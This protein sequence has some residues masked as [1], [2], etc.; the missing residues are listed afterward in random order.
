V[1]RRSAISQ[2]PE[3]VRADLERELIDRG[4]AGY[5]ALSE[6]LAERGHEISK[7]ALHRHGS[8]LERRL[9]R[10][11]ASAEAAHLIVEA[12]GDD[13]GRQS[14]AA[15]ALV[16]TDLHE[17][18]MALDEAGEDDV[19]P[20]SRILLL[21]KAA[22]AI[23]DCTRATVTQKRFAREVREQALKDAADA[24]SA[25]AKRGGLSKDVAAELRR[26]ILGVAG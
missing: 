5:E 25:V 9:S 21:N 2:L 10:I 17:A 16:Q 8:R 11:K 26:E 1:P 6:W 24:A 23:A 22:R 7:S 3:E 18:L 19:D 20:A 14:A 4:F 13:E 12:A 15:L